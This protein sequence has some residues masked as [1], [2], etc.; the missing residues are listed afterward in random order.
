MLTD[1]LCESSTNCRLLL[2]QSISFGGEAHRRV[3]QH[4][5]ARMTLSHSFVPLIMNALLELLH[6]S[7]SVG[8]KVKQI[9][10][11]QASS[12]YTYSIYVDNLAKCLFLNDTCLE[13]T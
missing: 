5:T 7:C 13:K 9:M 2:S 3:S 10:L 6:K 4:Q 1:C 12:H 8:L 11:S